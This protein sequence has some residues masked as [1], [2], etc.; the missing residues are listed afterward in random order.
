ARW[1][2]RTRR[3]PPSW[4]TSP[5]TRWPRRTE[6]P[7]IIPVVRPMLEE[8]I[9]AARQEQAAGHWDDAIAGYEAALRRVPG[10]G[11]AGQTADIMRRIGIVHRDRGDLDLAMELCEASLCIAE[12]C[13]L[14]DREAS[15]LICIA[16]I[17]QMRGELN[18]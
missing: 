6:R 18:V 16:T 10:E 17:H 3:S 1:T 7:W 11:D 8:L 14:P 4:T 2:S 15:A 13:A 12:L 5:A 9:E